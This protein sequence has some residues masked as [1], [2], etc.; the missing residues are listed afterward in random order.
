VSEY[1]KVQYWDLVASTSVDRTDYLQQVGRKTNSWEYPTNEQIDLI[2][3]SISSQ[4]SLNSND[5]LLDIGCGNGWLTSK[6]FSSVSKTLGVDPGEYFIETV[7]KTDFGNPGTND[8]LR[9]TAQ[10]Y[11]M[12]PQ[13]PSRFTKVLMCGM[14]EYL[15]DEH[16]SNVL[17]SI[18]QNFTNVSKVFI[19]NC[20]DKN[21]ID[22]YYNAV[23]QED[24]EDG[25]K[26][27]L[28]NYLGIWRTREEISQIASQAGWTA[29]VVEV[30]DG[31]Y[32]D[33]RY[34]VLLER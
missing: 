20:A 30:P 21:T 22:N 14:S 5:E 10:E 19:D 13:N 34:S 4:L 29:T 1:Y 26:G 9:S 17:E 11:T 25:E 31:Y 24:Y 7:A 6:F 15:S 12:N 32:Y 28:D 27:T 8:F 2:V 16:L 23:E 33:D 3:E 18:N